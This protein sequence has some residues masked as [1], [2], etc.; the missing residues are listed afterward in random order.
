M[1]NFK[2]K[3][4]QKVFASLRLGM[5]NCITVPIILCVFLLILLCFPL[6]F[7]ASWETL[8]LLHFY[9]H[10]QSVD[11]RV[12]QA[13][14]E[15]AD[16][17]YQTITKDVGF[18]PQRKIAVYLCPTPECFSQKQATSV[19]LPKWA[20]GVAYPALN[21][22]VIRSTLTVQER[23]GVQPI[24]IFKHEFAHIVLEQ[25]LEKRGGA[26]RWL[27]E[28]FSMYHARQWTIS[29]QR[30]LEEVTLR[31]SFIPLTMLTTVFPSDENTARIAYIQSFSLV[32]FLLNDEKYGRRIFHK[33]IEN[34]KEGMDTNTA[35][36]HSA[37][38]S[39]KRLELE[40][41]AALKKRYSWLNYL[42]DIGLFW[43]VLSV[44]FVIIYLLKRHKMKRIREQWEEE[45]L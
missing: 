35:L 23:G 32:N 3:T 39:L 40:W 13:L 11:N 42:G 43:F 20:V 16:T 44:G 10:Y 14:A 7:A 31:D 2:R 29:G 45:D 6:S 41:Q 26:P 1:D 22:I 30:T 19:N 15:Q 18:T 8:Q 38:V 27:S 21:R 33:F 36:L 17:I 24:E 25:A 4:V 37:G 5:I 12:A 34:L 28:G 9:V